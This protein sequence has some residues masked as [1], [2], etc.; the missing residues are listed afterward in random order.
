[1]KKALALVA[2]AVLIASVAAAE[3]NPTKQNPNN[4][5]TGPMVAETPGT[6]NSLTITG[7]QVGPLQVQVDASGSTVGGDGLPRVFNTGGGGTVTLND[8]FW[9][10]AQIYD[11]PW[12]GGCSSWATP[13]PNW[14]GYGSNSAVS[15][16]N[17]SLNVSFTTTVP[18]AQNYQ[19]FALA[20][21]GAT[22]PATSYLFGYVDSSVAI[23]PVG[24]TYIGSTVVPTPTPPPPLG[25]REPIPT[26]G[27]FGIIAMIMMFIGVAILVMYRRS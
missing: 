19:L 26:L 17:A 22:W 14:C 1:M 20:V 10:Y 5:V 9:L 16:A 24:T 18:A 15:T 12:Q 4:T 3:M 8:I 13:G 21:A 11:S 23:G 7:T 6:I 2:F 25:A 27:T